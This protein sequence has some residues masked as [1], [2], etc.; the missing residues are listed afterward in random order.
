M[1]GGNIGNIWSRILEDDDMSKRL[2]SCFK[3]VQTEKKKKK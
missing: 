3:K 1:I 2:F